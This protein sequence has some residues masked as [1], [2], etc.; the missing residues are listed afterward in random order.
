MLPKLLLLLL[1]LLLQLVRL[2]WLLRRLLWP[3]AGAAPLQS[4]TGRGF[5]RLLMP[6][7]K[8]RPLRSFSMWAA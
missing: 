7:M 4:C 5:N 1:E 3:L 8:A 2:L 6:R